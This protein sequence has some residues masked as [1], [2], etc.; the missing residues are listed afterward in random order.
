M[1]N[2]I[3][4]RAFTIVELV[5]V[6]AVI[7][8]LA[9]VLI[10]TFSNLVKKAQVS[11][12]TQLIRNLNTALTVDKATGN[13]HNTMTDALKAAK[14]S[15]Y[16]V[17]KI[18]AS[19]TDNEILWDGINDAFCYL[20]GKQLENGNGN[21]KYLPEMK[22]ET[23]KD[24]LKSYDY[25]KIYT[26]DDRNIVNQSEGQTFSI[27][28]GGKDYNGTVELQV[29]FDAGENTGITTVNYTNNSG[30]AK[31]VVIRTKGAST[32]LT[33]NTTSGNVN[34]YGSLGKLI[35]TE[36]PYD[37]YYEY[38][39][40][41]YAKVS[42]GKI[43]AKTGGEIAIL[44]AFAAAVSAKEDGG[45][46]TN[47]YCV[48]TTAVEETDDGYTNFSN[49]KG[50]N[51]TF[52]YTDDGTAS[53]T[54]LTESTIEAEATETINE[55]IDREN[56][57][58]DVYILQNGA[59]ADSGTFATLAEFRDLVNAGETFAGYTI[60][61]QGNVKLDNVEWTP[62][63]TNEHPF[64]GYFDGNGYTISDFTIN[65]TES[66]NGIFG[67]VVGVTEGTSYKKTA[68]EVWDSDNYTLKDGT[69]SEDLFKTVIKNF[70]VTNFAIKTGE[71][72]A[73]AI[74]WA[75]NAYIEKI[76]VTNGTITDDSKQAG[77]IAGVVGV[78]GKNMVYSKLET[79]TDVT[80]TGS[81]HSVA[82]IVASIQ[83]GD[84]GNNHFV[85]VKDC[86]NRASVN[87]TENG[88]TNG[89]YPIAGVVAN[90]GSCAGLTSVIYNCH[91]EGNITAEDCD[92]ACG[93]VGQAGVCVKGI[94]GCTNSGNIT[95]SAYQ[96]GVAGIGITEAIPA[97]ACSNSGTLINNADSNKVYDIASSTSNLTIANET[98]ASVAELQ[99]RINDAI[100]TALTLILKDVTVEDTTG[101]LTIPG[102]VKSITSNKKIANSVI[103]NDSIISINLIGLEQTLSAERTIE[104]G[105]T[106]NKIT[107]LENTSMQEIILTGS[108]NE[109]INNGSLGRI[110]VQGNGVGLSITN[111]GVLGGLSLVGTTATVELTNR[112]TISSE[113]SA[114]HVEAACTLTIYNYGTISADRFSMLLYDGC[115]V[116]I[117]AYSE[118]KV[119]GTFAPYRGENTI[120]VN[121]QD[122]A[123]INDNSWTTVESSRY[124][125]VV[126]RLG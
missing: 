93:I 46:I 121:Y 110:R 53:G 11:K 28:L 107:I 103:L 105:G 52:K 18:N 19:N 106:N 29:G 99:T 58:G 65:S 2:K 32:T 54:P 92:Y 94:Y 17:E 78:S 76:K 55:A 8:V 56:Y 25:W 102:N 38:G 40:T 95:A 14:E 118:S 91:N 9:G 84:S 73:A 51:V 30:I 117:N 100:G 112:G 115:N 116:T 90:A 6:I 39:Q 43:V 13:E 104:I 22:L 80:V 42:K 71:F 98:F 7:A 47:A 87:W 67:K 113:S 83:R 44:Y 27:Y 75:E 74:G 89:G 123:T 64:S 62:I 20:E 35:V 122:G 60:T 37:C 15:G 3:N 120:F 111:K 57:K 114:I 33:I 68:S 108:N 36:V 97:V 4:K 119:L 79:G 61:L 125:V 21:V 45:T 5:I 41:T 82:G 50:G 86:I 1:K 96:H 49:N 26:S 85:L 66:Y 23:E 48:S 77:K 24:Q 101:A 69:Y 16:D 59:I 34:H 63:G 31:D 72:G 70:N 88:Q 109:I 12:D 81:K 126:N 124:N 10:P